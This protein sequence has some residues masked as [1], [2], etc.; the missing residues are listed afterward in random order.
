[1]DFPIKLLLV[2]LVMRSD[3]MA[4]SVTGRT[5]LIRKSRRRGYGRNKHS[6]FSRFR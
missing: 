4:T 5:Y 6:R 3:P 1:M 2:W